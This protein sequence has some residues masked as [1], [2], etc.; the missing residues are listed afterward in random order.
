MLWWRL[1]KRSVAWAGLP[2][3]EKNELARQPNDKYNVSNTS[4]ARFLFVIAPNQS[5]R[6]L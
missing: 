5:L 6:M 3:R 4:P 2:R 1:G